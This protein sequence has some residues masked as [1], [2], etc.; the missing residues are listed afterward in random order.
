MSTCTV[1]EL[2]LV[3]KE[4]AGE[5]D[6]IQLDGEILDER[7][8][9]LGYDSLAVLETASAMERRYGIEL[10]DDLVGEAETPR[11]FLDLVNAQ[12]A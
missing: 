12:M 5:D 3:M 8:E 4:C 1:D 10:P 2:R 6:E 9:E 7:F 11:A